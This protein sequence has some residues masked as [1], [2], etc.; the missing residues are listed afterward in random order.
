MRWLGA[1]LPIAMS[2]TV[3]AAGLIHAVQVGGLFREAD[4]GTAAHLFQLL[5]PAQLPIIA[6]FAVTQLPRDSA[7]A[8]RV[9][10]VQLAAAVAVIAPVFLLNL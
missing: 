4:E 8:L 3:I 1:I 2:L 10:A 6:L 5:M 9:L 7:W